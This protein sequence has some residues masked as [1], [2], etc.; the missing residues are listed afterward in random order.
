[1]FYYVTI[2]VPDLDPDPEIPKFLDLPD[3]D[4]FVRGTDPDPF[5]SR[6]GV[7]RTEIMLAKLNLKQKIFLLKFNFNH[8]TWF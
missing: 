8:Q 3:P 5:L 4:P 6:K 2:T 7:E 1:M